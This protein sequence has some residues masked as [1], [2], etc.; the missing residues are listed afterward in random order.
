MTLCMT[1]I[2]AI[3]LTLDHN[4][5][6]DTFHYLDCVSYQLGHSRYFDHGHMHL[7]LVL[8]HQ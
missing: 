4:H 5:Y 1:M 7:A 3:T 6:F 8:D 2:M